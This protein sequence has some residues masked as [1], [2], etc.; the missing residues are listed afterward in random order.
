[1]LRLAVGEIHIDAKHLAEKLAQVLRAILGIVAGAAVAHADVQ[2]TVGTEGDHSAVVVLIRLR[3]GEK[4][5]LLHAVTIFRDDRRTVGLPRI[6][7]EEAPIRG[8]LRM[9]CKPQQAT[10]AAIKDT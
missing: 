4:N 2:I 1:N 6:V 9:K 10:L 3:D 8:E 5:S 7:H